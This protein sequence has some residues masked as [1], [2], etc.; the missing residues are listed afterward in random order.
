MAVE[1]IALIIFAGFLRD[2]T[3]SYVIA[4]NMLTACN[5]C[6]VIP[7]SIEAVIRLTCKKTAI[8]V[9]KT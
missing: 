1:T 6:C 9:P 4:F 3:G 2:Y 7:W 8:K 5:L